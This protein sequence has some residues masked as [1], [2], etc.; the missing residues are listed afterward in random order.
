MIP[1]QQLHLHLTAEGRLLRRANSAAYLII[2]Y[3]TAQHWYY[4][5]LAGPYIWHRL[6]GPDYHGQRR[7]AIQ[8]VYDMPEEAY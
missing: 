2:Q 7:W 4:V 8:G 3:D 5:L 1:R 6:A